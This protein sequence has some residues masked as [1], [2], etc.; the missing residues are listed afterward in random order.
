MDGW[1]VTERQR[2]RLERQLK[3]TTDARVYRRTLAL[4]E[5]SQGTPIA[6]VARTL[7][8]SRQSVYN[9]LESFGRTHDPA[10][11]QEAMHPGR[12]KSLTADLEVFLRSLMTMSPDQRGY[13]STT[14]TVP[15]LQEEL[16]HCCGTQVSDDTIRRELSRL[17]YVWKRARYVL[18]PDPE[19]EK[20]TANSPAHPGL[21]AT[22]CVVGGR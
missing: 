3:H 21:A 22:E 20:K 2:H 17:G 16:K 1:M 6:E 15:L 9:W 8:V 14:W 19:E 7:G 4:L 5:V 11:L 13:F 12:P 18:R 10:A